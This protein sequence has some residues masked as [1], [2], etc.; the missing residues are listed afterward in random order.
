MS[1]VEET[2]A[3]LVHYKLELDLE[4]ETIE[5]QELLKNCQLSNCQKLRIQGVRAL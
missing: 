5:T 3:S 2:R 4:R 1:L